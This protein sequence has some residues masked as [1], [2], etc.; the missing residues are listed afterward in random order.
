MILKKLVSSCC[1]AKGIC[2]CDKQAASKSL[3]RREL[4][5]LHPACAMMLMNL[6]LLLS[7]FATAASQSLARDGLYCTPWSGS[8]DGAAI[9]SQHEGHCWILGKLLDAPPVHLNGHSTFSLG[10][11][12]E[13]SDPWHLRD[14]KTIITNPILVL[15][16][17]R[18]CRWCLT[19]V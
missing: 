6:M 17:D 14:I 5:V 13:W 11:V 19:C 2:R 18:G 15:S 8:N 7:P 9:K 1:T 16:G 12:W 10:R 3:H 4:L